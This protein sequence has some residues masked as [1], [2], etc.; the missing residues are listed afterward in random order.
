[1]GAGWESDR[2]E[3][4]AILK[5]PLKELEDLDSGGHGSGQLPT[6]L[7]GNLG[8]REAQECS[9][10]TASPG[11][12]WGQNPASGLTKPDVGTWGRAEGGMASALR[13]PRKHGWRQLQWWASQGDFQV[14]MSSA[15]AASCDPCLCFLLP[16]PE[17]ATENSSS[18]EVVAEC[19][20]SSVPWPL[21]PQLDSRGDAICPGNSQS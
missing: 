8:P 15:L 6:T 2:Q 13:A 17:R 19:S 1:M 12:R 14:E 7:T 11:R 18:G 10:H 5:R 3:D 4:T 16:A 21:S 20:L 9:S